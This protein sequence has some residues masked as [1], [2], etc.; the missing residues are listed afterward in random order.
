[1]PVHDNLGVRTMRRAMKSAV[2]VAAAAAMVATSGATAALATDDNLKDQL[3]AGASTSFVAGGS[4]AL[5]Y[6]LQ[7]NGSNGCDASAAAP[8]AVTVGAPA[9]LSA[10]PSSFSL[11]T[12]RSGGTLNG[13]TVTFSS[14]TPGSY[15]V[16]P[17][18]SGGSGP[19]YTSTTTTFTVSAS[20]DSTAPVVVPTVVGTS[21]SNGWYTSDVAVSWSVTDAESA[22]TSTSGCGPQTLTAETAGSTVTCTA[23]SAGGTTTVSRTIKIDK[24][25]PTATLSSAGTA[26]A[27]DWFVSDVDVT[28]SGADTISGPVTCT[29]LQTLTA[30]TAGQPVDGT[31][32]NSAGL[33][34][35]AETL[36]VKIDKTAPTAVTS[37]VTSGTAGTGGW[38]TSDVTVSTTGTDGISG[39]TC[40]SA[41]LTTSTSG[42]S[43]PGS[44]TNGAGLV[45]NAAPITV[46][47]DKTGPTAALSITAGTLGSGGWYTDDVTVSTTGADDESAVSSCTADQHLTSDTTADGQDFAGSCTNGAGTETQAA[48]LT[49]KRDASAPTAQLVATGTEGANG[50][51]TSAV[52]VVVQGSD[53]QSGVTCFGGGAT[54]GD[55]TGT[56]FTG[57]C[58]NGAGLRTDATPLPVQVDT[59]APSAEL[60]VTAGTLGLN[61]WYTSDVTVSAT[62]ADAVSGPVSCTPATQSIAT[63]SAANTADA[64]CTNQAGLSASAAQLVVKLDKSAPTDVVSSVTSG[65]AGTNDWY[66]SDVTVGTTGT[67][68][69]SGVSCTAPVVLQDETTGTEAAGS[70]TNG[71]GLSAG[72]PSLV[73]K[74]DKT[75]PTDVAIAVASGTLGSNGWYRT[76]VTLRTTGSETVAS[77]VTCTADQVITVDAGATVFTGSCT[78]GA[79]LSSAPA[80]ITIARD[81]TAPTG[82]TFGGPAD[83]AVYDLG[84]VPA[85]VT[86]CSATDPTSGVAGCTVSGYG[87]GLGAH[88]VTATATDNAGNTATIT[89]TYRV[90]YPWSGFFQPID[91]ADGGK[92]KDSVVS[93]TTVFNKVKAGSAIPV[94]FSLGGD[95]GLGIFATGYPK[96]Q[97]VTCTSATATADPIEETATTSG[98]KYDATTQQY[99]YAWKTATSFAGSCQKLEVKLVD[100]E[101]YYAFFTFTK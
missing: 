75:A 20:P 44:C 42:T 23:T 80:S 17:S 96:V 12:C 26:G 72:A 49:V 33:S 93:G 25:G 54:T 53:A 32:T 5:T 61:G 34:T 6:Y 30:E 58:V 45:T 1:V 19:G 31:C 91:T 60:A 52:T 43:V 85:E 78:N 76:D 68:A 28:T 63:E 4:S 84:S 16:T 29:P 14:S 15:S 89:R 38:Y 66:T 87:S 70:C 86:T 55:T 77:P 82:I 74:I 79:G 81:A 8:V 71:A 35:S 83:G 97:K 46:M 59:T 9:G 73:V 88:T 95:R 101:S 39:V 65:T 22:V 36:T 94:K 64:T 11:V 27:D 92:G 99:N 56:T 98:L 10:S 67:D 100:G 13:V 37:A 40:T 69:L 3:V 18:L 7:S 2:A 48:P 50:W 90:V 47:I 51:Y 21:G 41:T 57:Y 24:T 62:G